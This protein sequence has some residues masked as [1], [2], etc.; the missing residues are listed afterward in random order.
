MSSFSIDQ[1]VVLLPKNVIPAYTVQLIAFEIA[2]GSVFRRWVVAVYSLVK[3]VSLILFFTRCDKI[4]PEDPIEISDKDFINALIDEGVDTN[5]DGLISYAEAE[6]IT[7]LD[8]SHDNISDLTGIE[9]FVNLDSLDCSLNQLTNLDVSKNTNLLYL[10]CVDNQLTT[11]NFIN[12]PKLVT[13]WCSYNQLTALDVSNNTALSYLDC[14]MNELTSL[15]ISNNTTLTFLSCSYNQL[16][17][18]DVSKNNAVDW[19]DIHHMP[20][21]YQVCVWEM[22]FPPDGVY[23]DT[24]GSPNVYFTTECSK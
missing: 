20:T 24:N 6:M 17:N 8:V 22:P 13:L 3:T 12:N 18:L 23:L 19:L 5:G 21:L 10:A 4:N 16:T 2:G 9:K 15:D 7:Y 1:C 14:L 11:L